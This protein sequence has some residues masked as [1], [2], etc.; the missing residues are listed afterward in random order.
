M[1]L[2]YSIENESFKINWFINLNQ[3]LN[4]NPSSI[5]KGNQIINNEKFIIA[6]SNKSTYILDN[7]MA[8]FCLRKISP[9]K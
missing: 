3:T 5:F 4:L 1:D 7:K 8:Q 2:L 9:L 6:S